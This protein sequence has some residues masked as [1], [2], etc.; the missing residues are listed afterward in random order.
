LQK[1]WLKNSQSTDFETNTGLHS[2]SRDP[3]DAKDGRSVGDEA[4]AAA[5]GAA[6]VGHFLTPTRIAK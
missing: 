2:Q 4:E 3:T 1:D 6:T 5:S